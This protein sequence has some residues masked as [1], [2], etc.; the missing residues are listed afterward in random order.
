MPRD[1]VQRAVRHDGVVVRNTTMPPRARYGGVG[2]DGKARVGGVGGARAPW[3]R[4]PR[5]DRGGRRCRR[6]IRCRRRSLRRSH[7]SGWRAGLR[8]IRREEPVV[9]RDRDTDI[10]T[11][12]RFRDRSDAVHGALGQPACTVSSDSVVGHRETGA[13]TRSSG[14]GRAGQ[15]SSSRHSLRLPVGL[16]S[17][18]SASQSGRRDS[19]NSRAILNGGRA[20]RA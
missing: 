16:Q 14:N 15:L 10:R 9:H 18:R 17:S 8:Q 5:S 2:G 4:A 12:R 20:G 11:F 7:P 19:R 6:W 1:A 3:R 13:S